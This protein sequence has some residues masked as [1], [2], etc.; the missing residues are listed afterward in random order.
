MTAIST[1]EIQKFVDH[2]LK[3]PTNGYLGSPYGQ[4]LPSLLQRA[5]SEP[6]ADAFLD[7][8]RADVAIFTAMPQGS[9]NLYGVRVPPDRLNLVIDVAGTLIEIPTDA[10]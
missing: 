7:K 4:D 8:L 2:W 1:K 3:T 6:A 9:V 5:L 10:N